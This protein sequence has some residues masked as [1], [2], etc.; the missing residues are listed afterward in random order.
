MKPHAAIMS[1]PQ[2]YP[3]T[4]EPL[5]INQENLQKA[6]HEFRG[7]VNHGTHLVQQGCPPSAEWGSAGLYLGV[8]G[9]V[10]SPFQNRRRQTYTHRTPLK[11][12]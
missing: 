1:A 11:S 2:Y 3:N 9:T 5:Q 7:A 8:A 10:D 4:L 6:L 12:L